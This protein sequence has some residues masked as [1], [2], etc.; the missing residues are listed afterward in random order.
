MRDVVE[1]NAELSA[2]YTKAVNSPIFVDSL[3]A[4]ISS[5]GRRGSEGAE[6]GSSGDPVGWQS[7]LRG[8]KL[9]FVRSLQTGLK[10]ILPNKQTLSIVAVNDH[11]SG[12]S[13]SHQSISFVESVNGG[14]E[15]TLLVNVPAVQSPITMEIAVCSGVCQVLSLDITLS[16]SLACI[17]T[18]AVSVVHAQTAQSGDNEPSG[19]ALHLLN[20]LRIGN[21]Q[22]T[23][24]ESL[25][26]VPGELVTEGDKTLLELRPFRVFRQGEII[27]YEESAVGSDGDESVL[28]SVPVSAGATRYGRIVS[29]GEASETGIRRL[30]V[31]IAA[32][33]VCVKLSTEVYSFKSAR[34]VGSAPQQRASSSSGGAVHNRQ[35][36]SSAAHSHAPIASST[37]QTSSTSS[38]TTLSAHIGQDELL[39][40][41]SG[42]L[43]RAGVPVSLEQQVPCTA[44]LHSL[45]VVDCTFLLFSGDDQQDC[46]S[47]VLREALADRA[48]G[49]EVCV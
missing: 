28:A 35:T 41:V 16:T 32:N 38:S 23:V 45:K 31:K 47:G 17:L 33:A 29:V 10:F 15:S 26:G 27:A 43:T 37:L 30:T 34:E 46:G 40:V 18:A 19:A 4:L 8:V 25:R 42:L 44:S 48:A 12:G 9:V 49:G 11:Q 1:N 21:D 20:L 3:S 14:A 39:S 22:H 5:G 7:K 13:G 6:S 24:R 2:L 36:A